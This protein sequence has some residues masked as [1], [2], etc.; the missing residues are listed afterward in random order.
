MTLVFL[1]FLFLLIFGTPIVFSLG[2]A[3]SLSLITYNVPI[4]IVAQRIYG[5]LDK[6]T[7][8]AIPFFILT[9]IIMERGGIA[10]RI[11]DFASA[12]VGWITGSL[13]LVAVVAGTG[14]AAISGS[15]S[16]DTAAMSSIMLPEMKKRKYNID[17]SAA[18]MACSGSLGTIIPPSIMMVVL[19][20]V[21]NLSVGA[22]FLAG[23]IPG[24]L[25]AFFLLISGYMR[26]KFVDTQ[27]TDKIS[28]SFSRLASSFY[29]AI[30]AFFLPIII[31]GGIIGGFFTPTE[32]ASIAVI[33]GFVISI[34]IYK[35]IKFKDLPEM[36]V[37]AAMIS[38]TVML[39]IS[40]ASI[41]SW[42]IASQQ[43]PQ[44]ISV[45]VNEFSSNK[46]VFLINI[47]LLL[48][49]IGM[50]MESISAILILM[51]VLMPLALSFGI[52]PL[53][54]GFI[55]ILNL[56][57]GLFTPPYGITLFVASSIAERSI[58]DV[59]K[60]I[61]IPLCLMLIVLLITTFFP[62]IAL[63]LPNKFIKN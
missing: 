44:K 59:S 27:T 58:V 43:I 47:N 40:T 11:I 54:F 9:G 41:F 52:D 24:L 63:Y 55:V 14:M 51:P 30:P 50:F 36:I 31:V 1:I 3:A 57:I 2:I 46:Y 18:I 4:A 25:C 34:F 6:F 62:E 7:I 45:F 48:I 61:I 10:K 12:L 5:G 13:Y 49:L 23:I 35:E 53:H 29:S 15:G 17:F 60:K 37:K 21:S 33:A 19:A 26:A 39:I 22:M 16:A 8:M 56:S 42:F 32:A 28:F 38:A 20:T